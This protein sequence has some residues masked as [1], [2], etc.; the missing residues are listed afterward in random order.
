M[1]LFPG[2]KVLLIKL[3]K[4]LFGVSYSW[5]PNGKLK[6]DLLLL[7]ISYFILLFGGCYKDFF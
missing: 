2:F 3:L 1:L 4:L 6:T 5:N 7:E